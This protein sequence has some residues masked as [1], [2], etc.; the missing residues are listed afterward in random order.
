MVMKTQLEEINC[1]QPEQ[2]EKYDKL[3]Y[4][5]LVK[6]M[7]KIL[8]HGIPEL[9]RIHSQIVKNMNSNGY[10]SFKIFLK[11]INSNRCL[12]DGVKKNMTGDT[13]DYHFEINTTHII[14]AMKTMEAL[15]WF[16]LSYV[17]GRLMIRSNFEHTLPNINSLMI[18]KEIITKDFLQNSGL[19]IYVRVKKDEVE[20]ILSEDTYVKHKTFKFW[21]SIHP[22]HYISETNDDDWV[23]VFFDSYEAIDSGFLIY[24][25][26][27]RAFCT[28]KNIPEKD[29][30]FFTIP[31]ELFKNSMCY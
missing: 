31:K 24:M 20:K 9:S 19:Q 3:N 21:T 6:L 1:F 5:P 2:I 18:S 22:S 13:N 30:F 29:K 11:I 8:P 14:N 15:T 23:N 26:E 4:I 10:I 12:S 7:K 17:S 28:K 25:I 27:G 16:D